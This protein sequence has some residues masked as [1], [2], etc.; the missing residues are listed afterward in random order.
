VL[1][2]AK[3]APQSI[4]D[5]DGEM[6]VV[7]TKRSADFQRQLQE[8]VAEAARFQAVYAY[9]R[10][11]DPSDWAGQTT[12]PFLAALSRAEVEEFARE[13]LAYT[14]DAARRETLENLDGNLRAWGAT[15]EIYE[16]PEVLAQM[17]AAIDYDKLEEVLPPPE[18]AAAA[19][20]EV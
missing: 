19:A 4:L 11:K 13:L 20:A 5:S 8:R 7:Q 3:E 9:N 17:T 15:A 10:D 12:F 1:D 2:M 6:L 14:L 18:A 16:D